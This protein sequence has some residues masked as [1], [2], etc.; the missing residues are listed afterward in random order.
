MYLR[1]DILKPFRRGR[2]PR[3]WN[4][5]VIGDLRRRSLLVELHR[6]PRRGPASSSTPRGDSS[7][8][9]HSCTLLYTEDSIPRPLCTCLNPEL[10]QRQRSRRTARSCGT[11]NFHIETERHLHADRQAGP[12]PAHVPRPPPRGHQGRMGID[13]RE[14]RARRRD[15]RVR[16]GG[17]RRRAELLCAR[18]LEHERG[19]GQHDV[20]RVER[21]HDVAPAEHRAG[22][23]ARRQ[24]HQV[25]RRR[26]L[27][28]QHLHPEADGRDAQP[29]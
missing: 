7:P 18:H 4:S 9:E 26:E 22:R 16:A 8:R 5:G 3:R 17:G 19:A 15:L 10:P 21:A 28:A 6:Q 11:L 14:R 2:G 24:P 12:H 23:R 25:P 20:E 1:D 13:A 27:P 29:A